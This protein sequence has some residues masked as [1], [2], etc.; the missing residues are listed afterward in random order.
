MLSNVVIKSFNVCQKNLA[1]SN[2]ILVLI[3][4]HNNDISKEYN[5]CIDLFEKHKKYSALYLE[6]VNEYN[7][8]LENAKN[9]VAI[10]SET[11]LTMEANTKT[12]VT[13]LMAFDEKIHVRH[14]QLMQNNDDMDR[15]KSI[16]LYNLPPVPTH[17]P[18]IRKGGKI[19][20]RKTKRRK[21]KRRK[22]KRR[23]T[24]CV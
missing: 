4:R 13:D 3:S 23:K 7:R 22:T 19:K 17:I 11:I 5:C 12:L 8:L 24:R 16:S 9:N 6:F 15:A 20:R 21:T 10:N 2:D 1:M 14:V 18:V